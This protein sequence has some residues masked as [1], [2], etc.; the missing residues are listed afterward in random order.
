MRSGA[1]SGVRTAQACN[2]SIIQT[3]WWG[4]C[5]SCLTASSHNTRGVYGWG[6]EGQ[7]LDCHVRAVS[8][9]QSCQVQEF[10]KILQVFNKPADA[11]ET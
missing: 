2:Q 1:R 11:D 8:H 7:Q 5:P 6:H 9:M 3:E 10:N 4:L